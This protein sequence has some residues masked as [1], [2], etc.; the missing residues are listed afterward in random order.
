MTEQS[1][2]KPKST[3]PKLIK[4]AEIPTKFIILKVMS[5]VIGITDATSNPALI[6]P[7]SITNTKMTINPPSNKFFSTVLMDLSMSLVLSIN[8]EMA[9]P[10]GNDFSTCCIRS[11]TPLIVASESAPLSINTIP[12]TASDSPLRVMAPYLMACP[13]PTSAMSLTS[14]GTPFLF[15]T[16][17]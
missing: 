3:A 1:T 13:K 11:F 8:A 4:L 12:P 15:F 10:S 5:M 16:T 17:I 9:K 6:L 2:S 7:M 14:T